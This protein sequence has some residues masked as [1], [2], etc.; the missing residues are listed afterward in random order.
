[1]F[2][3]ELEENVSFRQPLKWEDIKVTEFDG[4]YMVGGHAPGMKQ[5]L[6][7]GETGYCRRICAVSVLVGMRLCG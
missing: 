4:L 3:F 5:Y 2:Y 1:M 6:E 7:S